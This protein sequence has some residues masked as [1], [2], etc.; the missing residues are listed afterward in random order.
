ML[1]PVMTPLTLL[2]VAV[3]V[4][5][6]EA[7]FRLPLGFAM[8]QGLSIGKVLCLAGI[9]SVIF[10]ILH[11]GLDHIPVQGLSGFLDCILFIK[12]AG[13][14]RSIQKAM[15]AVVS[16]HYLYDL[17]LI[18]FLICSGGLTFRAW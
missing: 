11:G 1:W 6:E 14:G 2:D 15:V 10:G 9:S 4:S 18:V 5:F 3:L 8:R 16:T 17:A 13:G 12:C 7:V